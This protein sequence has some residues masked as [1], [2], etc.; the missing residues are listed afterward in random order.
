MAQQKTA[1]QDDSLIVISLFVILLAIY[2][3]VV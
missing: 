3:V 2:F 1:T